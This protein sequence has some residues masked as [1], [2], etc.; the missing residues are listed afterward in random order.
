MQ[1]NFQIIFNIVFFIFIA[2]IG[3]MFSYGSKLKK[4]NSDKDKKT[5]LAETIG[6]GVVVAFVFVVILIIDQVSK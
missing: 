3:L 5:A 4:A 1:E 2:V 6:V